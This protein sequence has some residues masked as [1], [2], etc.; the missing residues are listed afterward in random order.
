LDIKVSAVFPPI[1]TNAF[2]YCAVD[3]A[4][5]DMDGPLGSG[6]TRQEA[7]IALIERIAERD[8]TDPLQILLELVHS[9]E[10]PCNATN[11]PAC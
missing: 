6:A 10:T 2:D 11:Q 8:A 4:T 7:I 3:D 5:Y 1:P 9:K